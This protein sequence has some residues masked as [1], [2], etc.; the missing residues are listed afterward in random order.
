[1]ARFTMP[2]SSSFC[3]ND[4]QASSNHASPELKFVTCAHPGGIHRMAYWEWGESSN[5]DIVVCVHGLTRTG[6]DFDALGRSL[7]ERFRVICPDIA[8]RG[9]SDWLTNPMAYTVPQY[10]SDIL[11]LIARLDTSKVHWVGTSMGGLI[12]LGLAGALVMAQKQQ[13]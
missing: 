13:A 10:V 6:R 5:P 9:R 1:M 12:G 11:T 3:W 4:M 7:A 2:L 8:G